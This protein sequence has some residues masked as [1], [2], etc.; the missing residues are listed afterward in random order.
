MG[1][2]SKI[3]PDQLS[4]ELLLVRN[5]NGDTPLHLAAQYGHLDQVPQPLLNE[6]TLNQVNH[7]GVSVRRMAIS[8]GFAA[9]LPQSFRPKTSRFMGNF[10][11]RLGSIW[12]F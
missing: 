9:Q 12:T 4:T 1:Q 6:S 5:D 3:P 10:F 7:V 11:G 2:L 8:S